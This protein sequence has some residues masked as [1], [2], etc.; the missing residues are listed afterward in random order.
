MYILFIMLFGTLRMMDYF[1]FKLS[2]IV[3]SIYKNDE[4]K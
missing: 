1:P 2:C 3:H 4:N